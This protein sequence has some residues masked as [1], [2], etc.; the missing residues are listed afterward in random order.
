L[1][2]SYRKFRT[3]KNKILLNGFFFFKFQRK[4]AYSLK[5]EKEIRTILGKEEININQKEK[6]IFFSSV[7]FKIYNSSLVSK[8]LLETRYFILK[9][10]YKI[11]IERLHKKLSRTT[12]NTHFKIIRFEKN[13]KGRKINYESL[14]L[15]K[16][17]RFL[18]LFDNIFIFLVESNL[19]NNKSYFFIINW[20]LKN[21]KS[22]GIKTLKTVKKESASL[23]YR[24]IINNRLKNTKKLLL[25]IFQESKISLS[26]RDTLNL[27]SVQ[28]LNQ[29]KIQEKFFCNLML[30]SMT[31][32][33]QAFSKKKISYYVTT[34]SHSY[35][36]PLR[37]NLTRFFK[38]MYF[39]EKVN[40]FK[41]EQLKTIINLIICKNFNLLKNVEIQC[42][43]QI[44]NRFIKYDYINVSKYMYMELTS[45][46]N[47]D[48]FL[49]GLKIWVTIKTNNNLHLHQ[50]SGGQKSLSSLCLILSFHFFQPFKLYIFDEI[51]AA[52]DFK[53][54]KKISFQLKC[55]VNMT[56]LLIVTLRNN[57]VIYIDHLF[58]IY[59]FKKNTKIINLRV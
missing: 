18:K 29:N 54:V 47:L 4:I 42:C 43:L 11:S 37:S 21:D 52:L 34:T 22:K 58:I 59:K 10:K 46:D 39:E 13:L 1:Y 53:N 16:Y 45:I 5:S 36:A 26:K 6:I 32:H 7:R 9:L 50:L 38:R 48:I 17:K 31:E 15:K 24:M 44:T 56:Q 14:F 8:F 40:Q 27:I 20:Y 35:A 49:K 30:K 55:R 33:N 51:D 3:F 19:T 12:L 25:M 2:T 57:M 41:K 28:S 23:Y